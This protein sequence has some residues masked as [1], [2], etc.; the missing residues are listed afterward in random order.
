MPWVLLKKQKVHKEFQDEDD[1]YKSY[2]LSKK[3]VSSSRRRLRSAWLSIKTTEPGIVTLD[4]LF[5]VG[6]YDVNHDSFL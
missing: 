6:L 2:T 5:R 3:S 4:A 1:N